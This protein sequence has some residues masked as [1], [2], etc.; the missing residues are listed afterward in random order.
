MKSI[1][2]ATLIVSVIAALI[3]G[4]SALARAKVKGRFYSFSIMLFAS[5]LYAGFYAAELLQADLHGVLF[6]IGFEYICGAS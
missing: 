3:L 1:I 5:A 4:F 6:C 2:L